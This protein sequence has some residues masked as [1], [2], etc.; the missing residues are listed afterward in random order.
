MQGKI[1]LTALEKHYGRLVAVSRAQSGP[2]LYDAAS[3]LTVGIYKDKND[4]YPLVG[5]VAEAA[6]Y[7]GA[8]STAEVKA[9]AAETSPQ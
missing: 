1:T 2:V 6:I 4:H 8:L 3:R 9:R 5:S 7:R